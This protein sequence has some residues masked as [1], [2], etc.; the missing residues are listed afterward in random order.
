MLNLFI[1]IIPAA[2]FCIDL[3]AGFIYRSDQSERKYKHNVVNLNLRS[4]DLLFIED[5]VFR[6]AY[7]YGKHRL[8]QVS[9]CW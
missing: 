6:R 9:S 8:I 3:L 7:E 4:A 2:V 1:P 5:V